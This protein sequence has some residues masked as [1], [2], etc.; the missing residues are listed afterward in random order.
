M[1]DEETGQMVHQK[2][3]DES[4]KFYQYLRRAQEENR[5][6]VVAIGKVLLDNMKTM[7]ANSTQ[8]TGTLD[9]QLKS[10]IPSVLWHTSKL[11]IF[12]ARSLAAATTMPSHTG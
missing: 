1:V 7:I 8:V 2:S 10:P 11:P 5:A 4:S 6:I 3:Q 12:G 9:A